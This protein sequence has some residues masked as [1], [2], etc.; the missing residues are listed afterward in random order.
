MDPVGGRDV[1]A[2]GGHRVVAEDGG[3]EGVA[4]LLGG[5]G[6]VGGPAEVLDLVGGDGDDL[7][8]DEVDA[9]GVDDQGRVDAVEGAPVAQEDLAPA[10]LLGRRADDVEPAAGLGDDGGRGQG[11][12]Q[13]G[14][15]DDVVA[16]AVADAGQGVVL[17][18]HRDPGPV[19]A[20]VARGRPTKAVSSP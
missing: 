16:A 5:G 4:A 8:L 12:P 17:A 20:V 1:L 14:G 2:E 9:G 7:G 18:E 6:G 3:V 15:G 13:A 11:R 19:A 10:A